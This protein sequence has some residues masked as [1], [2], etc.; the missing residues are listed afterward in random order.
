MNGI[1]VNLASAELDEDVVPVSLAQQGVYMLAEFDATGTVNTIPAS[2]RIDGPLQ[3][4]VLEQAF[5]RM[6]QRHESLRTRF[7]M[8]PGG[9]VAI[10]DPYVPLHL[11]LIPLA[12]AND[13]DVD[14]HIGRLA[15]EAATQR[16]YPAP[17]LASL[18]RDELIAVDPA[19]ALVTLDHRVVRVFLAEERQLSVRRVVARPEGWEL[20][21]PFL[22]NTHVAC[23][24]DS[25][26]LSWCPR[27]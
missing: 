27:P 18:P 1:S 3:A 6:L 23:A 24:Q 17:E 25:S 2:V 16:W 11:P 22:R 21:G 19:A 12:I 14:T 8:E 13:K 9:L 20:P 5:N 15:R 26:W 7:R 4:G 10:V